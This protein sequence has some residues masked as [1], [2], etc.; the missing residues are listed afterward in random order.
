MLGW[1]VGSIVRSMRVGARL[2]LADVVRTRP[3]KMQTSQVQ[4]RR[5]WTRLA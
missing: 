4:T 1:V 5:G 3:L 2:A